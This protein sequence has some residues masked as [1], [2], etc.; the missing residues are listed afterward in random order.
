VQSDS[1]GSTPSSDSPGRSRD[2]EKRW[3]S[4]R[5]HDAMSGVLTLH[6]SGGRHVEAPESETRQ[7][8]ADPDMT[9]TLGALHCMGAAWS[10]THCSRAT[11]PYVA[12]VVRAR[13]EHSGVSK[14][15]PLEAGFV[16][17][18]PSWY[19]FSQSRL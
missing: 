11:S 5:E 14:S 3:R 10:R 13:G 15:P 1:A 17:S 9:A 7:V 19:S 12:R 16:C 2:D 6:L 8:R 4:E 18:A